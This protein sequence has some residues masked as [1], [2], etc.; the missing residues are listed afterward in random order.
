MKGDGR[1]SEG[2]VVCD[3]SLCRGRGT[4]SFFLL[5]LHLGIQTI[6][7]VTGRQHGDLTKILVYINI[8]SQYTYIFTQKRDTQ[9]E[10]GVHLIKKTLQ[11]A[12]YYYN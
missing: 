1:E 12:Y 8:N 5:L 9:L 4:W 3:Q 10:A 6:H 2:S 7:A 11:R